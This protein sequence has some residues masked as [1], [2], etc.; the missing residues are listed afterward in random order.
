MLGE[1]DLS[2]SLRG[3][4]THAFHAKAPKKHSRRVLKPQRLNP[5]SEALNNPKPGPGVLSSFASC[6]SVKERG[7]ARTCSKALTLG[8]WERCSAPGD[9][10]SGRT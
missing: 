5:D 4:L 9:F 6:D 7:C 10:A 1:T 8:T 2:N 3:G